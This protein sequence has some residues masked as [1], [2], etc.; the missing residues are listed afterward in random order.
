MDAGD[1]PDIFEILLNGELVED[2]VDEEGGGIDW[3]MWWQIIVHRNAGVHD[4]EMPDYPDAAWSLEPKDAPFPFSLGQTWYCAA[5]LAIL[6]AVHYEIDS[7]WLLNNGYINYLMRIT[8]K[9]LLT[10][11]ISFAST[12]LFECFGSV[13]DLIKE[14]YVQDI[15]IYTNAWFVERF[16]WGPVDENGRAAWNG[17]DGIQFHHDPTHL[18]QPF[19]NAVIA[20]ILNAF[21]YG[22]TLLFY[23]V[24]TSIGSGI[25]WLASLVSTDISD[26][27][28][29][30]STYLALPTPGMDGTTDLKTLLWE[31]GPPV[32]FQIWFAAFIYLFVFLFMSRAETPLILHDTGLDP[33]SKLA[34]NL[35]RATALHLLAY[36]AYQIAVGPAFVSALGSLYRVAID[37]D[38]KSNSTQ[39]G[40]L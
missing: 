12:L 3:D 5:V 9:T 7:E 8:S 24:P 6:L 36:T 13:V 27:L 11:A 37:Q 21:D 10:V 26:F 25:I 22:L 39:L 40:C 35:L 34:F 15:I 30:L 31:F 20:I 14:T 1:E 29:N 32:Y 38:R 18:R 17:E 23:L 19:L 2:S 4:A 28:S 16:H 33:F